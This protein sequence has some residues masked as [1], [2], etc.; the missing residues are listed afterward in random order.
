MLRNITFLFILLVS[1]SAYSQQMISSSYMPSKFFIKNEGQLINQYGE[2]NDEVLYLYH[3]GLFNLELKKDG[4]SYEIFK[5]EKDA[6]AVSE[7]Y[8]TLNQHDSDDEKYRSAKM[9][10]SRIDVSFS[11]SNSS[12]IVKTGEQL[13]GYFNYYHAPLSTNSFTR[14]GRYNKIIYEN[15][16]EGIDLVF[17]APEKNSVQQLRYEFIVHP[18]A[19]YSKIKFD[20]KGTSQLYKNKDGSLIISTLNGY[21]TET[22]PY[23][24]IDGNEK[25]IAANFILKKN[26]RSFSS[27]NY[28]RSKFMIIDPNILWGTYYGG[29]GG[30]EIAEVTVG[31]DLKPVIDGHT[32]S[33]YH[34][35]TTDGYQNDYGGGLYDWFIAKFKANGDL[36]W[37]TYFGGDDKDYCYGITVDPANNIIAVGNSQSQ[38][39]ATSGAFKDSVS[40]PDA[41]ILIAKFSPVGDLIW[42]TY[43]GGNSPENPRNVVTDYKGD[44]YLAGATASDSGIATPGAYQTE[45]GGLDDTW[46]AKFSVNGNRLWGTYYGDSGVDRSHALTLDHLGNLFVAG[47]CSSN[48]GIA[49]SG[50]QQT[51][52]G[53]GVADAFISKWDTTGNM[54]WGS[55]C[56]GTEEER[57]RG[58]ET[59][60]DGNVYLS[61]FTGSDTLIAT[62]DGFQPNWTTGYLGNKPTT[63]AFLVKYSTQGLRI[64]GTYYGGNKDEDLWGMTIDKSTNS[65]FI[66]GSSAS[67]SNIAYNNPMQANNAGYTDAFLAKFKTDGDIDWGTF[68]GGKSAEQFED[69]AVDTEHNIYACGRIATNSM[70]VTLGTYQQTYYGGYSD[71]IL[72]KFYPGFDCYDVYEPNES[73]AMAK[74]IKSYLVAEDST[75]Y[76]YNGSIKSGTDYDWYSILV[77]A[78]YPNLKIILSSLTKNYNLNLYDELGILQ[79]QA[80]SSG[81]I[82]DTL[83]ANNLQSGTYYLEVPHLETDFDSIHCYR[84][85]IYKSDS[86]FPDDTPD[87]IVEDHNTLQFSVYPNPS[88]DYLSFS[89]PTTTNENADVIIYDLMGRS[90]FSKTFLLSVKN[91]AVNISIKELSS[92]PYSLVVISAN[93]IRLSRFVKQ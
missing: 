20:Y 85:Q 15:L 82:P 2:A 33:Q 29:A 87:A 24:I 64:W 46:I 91:Q 50:T 40:G 90:V 74:S 30:D 56:G 80:S 67:L 41:D 59:D 13:S 69:V 65:I 77:D 1:S 57:C 78:T 81:I 62:P 79:F 6:P 9:S 31:T 3:D 61:G 84:I 66:A 16:Y 34:I 36:E 89:I 38:G 8:S 23:Y 73:I 47:T 27:L 68:Y 92:G 72:Y 51:S 93:Q 43:Y 17:Y 32:V 10:S 54:F 60:S 11:N 76:G 39:L 26:N 49:T 58:A 48:K 63:D 88:I 19:D 75:I 21:V 25:P 7:S 18:G 5:I 83:N 42:S 55:Y 14:A 70:Q 35:A 86:A 52:Y 37:G 71:A 12:C 53:G 28:D 22:K 45:I 4:F 44:I